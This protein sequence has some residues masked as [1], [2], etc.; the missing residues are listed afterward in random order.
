MEPLHLSF[1]K[2]S[3]LYKQTSPF[4]V[5]VFVKQYPGHRTAQ[6]DGPDFPSQDE[7]QVYTWFAHASYAFLLSLI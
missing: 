4:L 6:F 1:F 2:N 5:R 3:A 7:Y